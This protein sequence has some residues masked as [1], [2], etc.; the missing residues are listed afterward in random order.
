MATNSITTPEMECALANWLGY[1]A[2][3]IVPNVHWGLSGMHECDLL[4]VSRAGYLTEIEIKISRADL[5]ADAR[6]WHGHN[7]NRIKRL[8][9]AL[10]DYLEHCL[11]MV[12]ERA[13]II[14]VRAEDNVRGEYPYHPRCREIR[15]AKR[16][17]AAGKI[18]EADRYKVARLGALRIWN[19][20]RQINATAKDQRREP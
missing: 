6:K 13:G 9:F 10:P 20:K 12:P 14:L 5:R 2:N 19:L 3:L 4:V 1:R 17:K 7:S 15:A 18:S 8:F 11:H 16:N